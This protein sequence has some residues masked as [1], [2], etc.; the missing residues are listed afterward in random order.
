MLNGLR[1]VPEPSIEI[2]IFCTIKIGK[3]FKKQFIATTEIKII[4]YSSQKNY[5]SQFVW[6]SAW[7]LPYEPGGQGSGHMPRL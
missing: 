6:L 3:N 4:L 2:I 7:V 1:M 5:R